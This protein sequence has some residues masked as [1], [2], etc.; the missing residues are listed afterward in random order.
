[1]NP[2]L[3]QLSE[4]IP[5]N[6]A[7]RTIYNIEKEKYIIDKLKCKFYRYLEYENKLIEIL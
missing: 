2:S 6:D 3:I 1:M 7:E 5:V 4:F